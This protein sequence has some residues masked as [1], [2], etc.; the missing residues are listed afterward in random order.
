MTSGAKRRLFYGRVVM[1]TNTDG[2]GENPMGRI[3]VDV[4]VSNWYDMR[5]AQEGALPPEQVRH[6]QLQ[7][8][9]DTASTNLVLPTDTAERLGLP[10]VREVAVHY[11]DRRSAT[12]TLVDDARVELL[13]RDATFQAIL[14]PDRTTALIGAIV[15]EAL[16]L[17]VDCTHQCLVPR[18]PQRMTFEVE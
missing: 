12:R 11:A 16:D 1:S 6:F 8:V 3:V 17:L 2:K 4:L 9:V 7:G 10:K 18:D 15:L 5:K 13:G 14:E